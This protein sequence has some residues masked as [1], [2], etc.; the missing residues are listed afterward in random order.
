[1]IDSIRGI[2]LRSEPQLAVVECGGVGFACSVTFN[3]A[4]QLPAVGEEVR[5]YTVLNLREDAAELFGF[6]DPAER[7]CFTQLTAVSGVGVKAALSILSEL[8]PEK[9]AVAV[10]AGDV[11]AITRAKNVGTKLG[12]RVVLE[13]KDKL[14]FGVSGEAVLPAARGVPSA[15]S[16]GEQAVNALTVLGFSASE[17]SAAVAKLDGALPVNELVRQ[18]LRS[19]G[20]RG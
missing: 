4:R 19:L 13:L 9:L 2:L 8:T 12:Q 7:R 16:N 18:A 1:M 5:L 10:S 11:K 14:G 6:A 15:S 3:T 20:K 17:A